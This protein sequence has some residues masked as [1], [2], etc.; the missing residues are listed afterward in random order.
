M[1]LPRGVSAA[2]LIRAL[3]RLGYAVIRQKGATL[4]CF[5]KRRLLIRSLFRC[6]IL[7]RSAHFTE[8]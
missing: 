1:K 2:R 5:M 3:E 8:F 7:L 4:G 6:T